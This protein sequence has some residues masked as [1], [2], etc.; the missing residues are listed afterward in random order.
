VAAPMFLPLLLG[1]ARLPRRRGPA[2][3][4]AA[5]PGGAVGIVAGLILPTI[6]GTRWGAFL[7]LSVASLVVSTTYGAIAR[8]DDPAPP[9]V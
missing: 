4:L 6:V 5:L 8:P 2:L 3:V 9:S 7:A 1:T